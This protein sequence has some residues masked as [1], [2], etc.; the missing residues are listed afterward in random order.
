MIEY[1]GSKEKVDEEEFKKE[2]E[3]DWLKV[4]AC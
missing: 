4:R 2:R 1:H 3:N